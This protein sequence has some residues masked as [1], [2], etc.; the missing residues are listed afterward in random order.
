MQSQPGAL[1]KQEIIFNNPSR[2]TT[3]KGTQ[4]GMGKWLQ[5]QGMVPHTTVVLTK[6]TYFLSQ[7]HQ[8]LVTF[9]PLK[10]C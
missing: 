10:L 2:K 1:F 6:K 4:L 8:G 3:G 5:H 9:S 7:P